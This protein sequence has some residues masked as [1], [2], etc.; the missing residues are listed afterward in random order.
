MVGGLFR[1][2]ERGTRVGL[3]EKASGCFLGSRDKSGEVAAGWAFIIARG[4]MQTV[5]RRASICRRTTAGDHKGPP[6][7]APPPSPLQILMSFLLR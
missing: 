6:F 7:P 3:V 1:R 2:S 4:E 5:H